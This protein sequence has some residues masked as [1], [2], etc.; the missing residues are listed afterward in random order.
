MNRIVVSVVFMFLRLGFIL[1]CVVIVELLVC[2]VVFSLVSRLL[3]GLL[4]LR[5]V[6]V[7]I[8]NWDVILL[9]VCLF[10]L[11]V[12]VNSCVLV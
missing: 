7:V 12:R 4:L 3:L 8:I 1:I 11:L 6:N 5:W 2:I 10:M 9:V